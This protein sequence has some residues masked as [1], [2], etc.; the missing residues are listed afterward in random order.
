MSHF[1]FLHFLL[2]AACA[3]LAAVAPAQTIE[4][5]ARLDGF[6]EVPVVVTPAR[7]LAFVAIDTSAN[8]LTYRIVFGGLSSAETVAHIHGFAPA[9]S[10]AGV[11]NALPLGSPKC[12]VWTMTAAQQ[13]NVLADLSYVNIHSVI[14]PGG[15]IRGQIDI[16]PDQP[17]FCYGDGTGTACPCGNFSA[18]GDDE[19]CL[20]SGGVGARLRGYAGPAPSPSLSSDRLVLHVLR[21]PPNTPILF[22]QGTLAIAGGAGSVF[23]DGLRC[24][25]GNT[26]RLAIKQGCGGQVGLPEPGDLPISISGGIGTPSTMNYQAWYRNPPAFCTAST[27]N[28]TN[29][30]R[31][32]WVP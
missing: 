22:F 18:V 7:G 12:G 25:G 27:F 9:G 5:I 24:V 28:L 3:L 10:N 23:G 26:R 30:V 19:G 8:T 13:A 11:L 16:A 4:R 31:V 2:P 20:H 14:N 21:A 6:Q 15:E 1:R 32:N 17:T 29:G